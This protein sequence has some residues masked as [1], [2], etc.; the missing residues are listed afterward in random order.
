[1]YI[2]IETRQP[3]GS[4]LHLVALYTTHD[5]HTATNVVDYTINSVIAFK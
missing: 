5:D 1:M 3:C 2:Y 4:K